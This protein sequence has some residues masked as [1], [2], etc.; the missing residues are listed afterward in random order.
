MRDAAGGDE[1]LR[2]RIEESEDIDPADKEALL[3]FSDEMRFRK[4]EYSDNRHLKLLQHCTVLAGDSQKYSTEDLPDVRLVD[5]LESEEASKELVRWIHSNFE[6]VETNRDYRVALR[7]FGEYASDCDGKPESIEQVSASN[8]LVNKRDDLEQLI[9]R[10]S[11]AESAIEG[12]GGSI[13]TGN[14]RDS[15]GARK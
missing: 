13:R 8:T 2:E 14:Y 1:R 12:R 7:M 11:R 15:F 5:A 9:E 6:N 10:I 3:A 4:A